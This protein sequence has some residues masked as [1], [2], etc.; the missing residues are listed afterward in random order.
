L[1]TI[2]IGF[3][4]IAPKHLE[5]LK[6][7]NCEVAGIV[8]RNY[9]RAIIK[10]K[11]HGIKA[12]K[13]IDS[14]SFKE[15]DF[16]TILVSP[17]SNLEILKQII[18]FKKPILIEKPVTFN[19]KSLTELID[20][21]KKY[22][23]NI[24]VAMN[25]RFYSVFHKGLKYLEENDK[26]ISSV[27]IEAPERFSDIN[28]PKFSD[29]VRKNWM[30]SNSI[31][32]IDLIRFFGGDIRKIDTNSEPRKFVYSAIGHCDKDVEFTYISNWKSPG[33]WSVTL[34]ADN[35]RIMYN[36]LEKGTILENNEKKEIIP[37]KE[38]T[39]FKP[40]FYFQLKHFIEN[41]VNNNKF[42][43]PASDLID[44]NKTMELVEAIYHVNK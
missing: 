28:L 14:I 9:D 41:I 16:F 44:H 30:F 23:S 22:H 34:Y 6:E 29:I 1:R 42:V 17:E 2:V 38:D 26:K 8:T 11:N 37:D 21:N 10:A 33:S 39:L 3:G 5:V 25:R 19:S 32:C 40:G 7:F 12:Y 31:H 13:T 36:P 20:F 35:V 18:P 15:L 27:V 4:D 24:M 43:W